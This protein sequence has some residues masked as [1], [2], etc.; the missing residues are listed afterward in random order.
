MKNFLKIVFATMV[1]MLTTFTVMFF[2][3]VMIVSVLVGQSK[4]SDWTSAL[5]DVKDKSILRV[6]FNGPLVDHLERPDLISSIMKYDEPPAVGLYELTETLKTAGDDKRIKGLFLEIK[7][8]SGWF[9]NVEALRREII[10]FKA[11]GKFVIAYSETYSE[12][13]Y[14]LASAADEVI[15]YPRGFFEWDGLYSKLAFFKNTLSKLEVVPQVFRAGK[16]KSAIEPFINDQMSPESREQVQSLILNAWNQITGYAA[17]K[18]QTEKNSLDDLANNLSVIHAKQAFENKF[19]NYLSSFE[20][21]EKKFMELTDNKEKPE[22]TNWRIYYRNMIKDKKW[23]VGDRIALVFAEGE[24]VSG[25]GETGQI[26][27]DKLSKLLQDLAR[28]EEVKAVVVRVNSPGGSALA[29]DVI[30]TSTQWLKD[31][32][33]VVASFG[34]MAASGGYYMSA[35]ASYIFAEPTTITGSIGVFGLSFAT[36]KFWNNKIGMTFDTEKSHRFSDLESLVRT[37]DPEETRKMQSLVDIIYGDFL[38]VVVQGRKTL[39]TTEQVHEIAQ[40]R[41]WSGKEAKNIGL[42]D[43]FG[44][45]EEAVAKAAELAQMTDYQVEVFPKEKSPFEEFIVQFGGVSTKALK[46]MLPDALINLLEKTQSKANISERIYTRM[47]FDI[48]VN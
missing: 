36:Q 25:P 30:W 40:G 38:N 42:I 33:P 12:M 37:M 35:G 8:I 21:V 46:S 47:P 39:E 3:F 44:G 15:L 1:G 7:H 48:I 23:I 17:E 2:V 41:V 43:E 10:K 22:Y 18:T 20:D 27:S 9:A 31:K 13:G 26:S 6:E 45:I 24:I 4:N 16:Y 19:V 5:G 11:K 29:S 28:N 14:M 34:N 32:K